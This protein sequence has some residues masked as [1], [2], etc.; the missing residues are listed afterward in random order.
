MDDRNRGR[1]YH[2]LGPVT[3]HDDGVPV[4]LGGPKPRTILAAL[5]LNANRVVPE[6][7]LVALTWGEKW[8]ATVRGQVQVYVSGL[9]QRLGPATIVRRPPGYLITVR[10]GEL[11]LHDFDE[12]VASAQRE[13]GDPAARADL[14]RRAL[15]RWPGPELGGTTEAMRAARGPELRERRLGAAEEW[16]D[17][18]LAAGRH[19]EV[20]GPLWQAVRA[21]P[22]RERLHAQ[23]MLA[24]HGCG[25]TAEALEVYAA[26][27][28]RLADELGVDPGVVLRRAQQLL[29]RG[30]DSQS[31]APPV[32]VPRQLPAEL[33]GFV[34]RTRQLADLDAAARPGSG[35]RIVVVT[36]TAG[37]GKTALAVRWAHRAHARFPDGQLY[38]DLRG[39]DPGGPAMTAAEAVRGLLD[40]LQVPAGRIPVGLDAQVGL[41]RSLLA[42]RRV[43]VVLDNARDADQV[44]PVLPGAASCFT[45]VTSRADLAGLVAAQGA[46]PVPLDL[47]SPA[48]ACQMLARRLGA[49]RVRR[50]PRAVQDIISA[51][52][53]LPLAL[54]VVAARAAGRPSFPLSTLA[55]ELRAHH[56]LDRFDGGGPR[57]DLRAVLAV[58][59]RTLDAGTARVFRLL[60]LHPGPNVSVAAAASLTGLDEGAARRAL[61]TL[62]RAHLLDEPSP[63]R[64]GMHD[65]LREYAAELIGSGDGEGRRAATHRMLDHYL[66]T[67]LAADRLLNPRREA[68]AP[69]PP[70]SGT[71][72]EAPADARE[73]MRWFGAEHPVLVA[74]VLTTP[75]GFDAHRWQLAWALVTYFD[76]QGHWADYVAVHHAA[77]DATEHDA[78]PLPRAHAL[79]NLGRAYGLLRR[80]PEADS[81]LRQALALYDHHGDDA[82]AAHVHGN[83]SWVAE[84][85]GRFRDALHHAREAMRRYERLGDRVM[86]A[87]ALNTVGW[88]HAQLGE[89]DQAFRDCRAALALLREAGDRFGEAVTWDS[90]G[91]IHQRRGEPREA[92]AGYRRALELFQEAGDLNNE[93]QTLAKLAAAYDL[94]GEPALARRS[95]QE[96][97]RIF[98]GLG[99]PDAGKLRAELDRGGRATDAEPVQERDCTA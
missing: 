11:D 68:I 26:V 79:R 6:E 51:S 19:A 61:V 32:T 18:E 13:T 9:R 41:Y 46:V 3:V 74:L 49:D 76:R 85:D 72:P 44:R 21:E 1:R 48:E 86:A 95:R 38:V 81:H 57:S 77:L 80:L 10:P 30:D 99:H 20:V 27:R 24:L 15:A 90:L 45:L 65:L 47:F 62:T 64:F 39:F 43:L 23:L 56:R 50:E 78:G 63:G 8:P 36:G 88:Q 97:L 16:Y 53:R 69:V 84:R 37:V 87:N 93:G 12:A 22:F 5:L 71:R 40:A 94:T 58:S 73:A 33:P 25:R 31:A 55:A 28:A 67:A 60:G 96:A 54:A 70:R 52:A 2:L 35:A 91:Y 14:L 17:A 83:L 59:Y 34:G 29:L 4:P 89:L 75:A 98:D 42:D 7:Q 92:V 82:G 66:H